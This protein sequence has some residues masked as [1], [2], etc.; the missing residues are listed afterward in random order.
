MTQTL[1]AFQAQH[2]GAY[3]DYDG[4]YGAQ[5]VDLIDFY[6]RDVLGIPIVW[7]NAV[8]W[9]QRDG[10]YLQWTANRVGDPSSKPARGDIVVWG[11]DQRVG[12]G[13]F[14]HIAICLDPGD[15]LR[16]LSLDQNWPAGAPV[17]VITHTFEGVIGWGDRPRL[18]APLTTFP[19]AP[20]AYGQWLSARRA[21]VV[22]HDPLAQFGQYLKEAYPNRDDL[23]QHG[24]APGDW[25]QQLLGEAAREVTGQL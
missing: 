10:A 8:D 2:L 20:V 4:L 5:C 12:T 9:W 24:R 15:G 6:C 21:D 23:Q 19:L 16:F 7:A 13:V 17:S 1:D 14:G 3:L 22:G 18:A 25:L 11:P